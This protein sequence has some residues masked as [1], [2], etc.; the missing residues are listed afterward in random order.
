[1]EGEK[2]PMFE[3]AETLATKGEYYSPMS[4]EAMGITQSLTICGVKIR[5]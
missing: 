1:L 4:E 5:R 2:I 3:K